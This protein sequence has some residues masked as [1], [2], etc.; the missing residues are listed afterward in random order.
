MEPRIQYAQTADGVS[1]KGGKR[2]PSLPRLYR[3]LAPWWPLLSAPAEYAE[4]A[5]FYRR[6]IIEACKRPPRTLLELGC[7]G[8]NNASFLKAHFRMTLVDVSPEMLTVSRA[9]NPEC[10]HLEGDMRTVRLRRRFDAVFIHDAIAYMTTE[11]DLCGALETAFVHCRPGGAAIFCPDYIRENFRP[12]TNHGGHDGQLRSLRYLEWI[13][14]PDPAD[15]TYV[16]D[17]AY[18]LR[19]QD[20]SVRTE[21]ERHVLGLFGRQDWLRLLAAVGFEARA[22][23]FEHSEIDPGTHE[24]FVGAKAGDQR[25]RTQSDRSN[26]GKGRG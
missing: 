18:L 26:C 7:G 12:A 21:H 1:T 10:A 20:G 14:D 8:G 22:V 9:L 5:A 19:E 25:L 23:P 3:E 16:A 24:V 13:W 17:F 2:K 6:L 11:R 4:E 15:T